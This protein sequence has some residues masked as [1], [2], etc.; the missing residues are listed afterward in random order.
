M[1]SQEERT[2]QPEEHHA[3]YL[4]R[5]LEA[6]TGSTLQTAGSA[7]WLAKNTGIQVH[8]RHTA[9]QAM[10]GLEMALGEDGNNP[11]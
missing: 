7:F 2:R 9:Q 10:E 8:P 6:V 3:D 5:V 1:I 11:W 4:E